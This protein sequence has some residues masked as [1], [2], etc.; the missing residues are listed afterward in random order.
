[1]RVHQGRR[2]LASLQTLVKCLNIEYERTPIYISAL[3]MMVG[4]IK[5]L[6]EGCLLGNKTVPRGVKSLFAP[7]SEGTFSHA[8][9]YNP[10]KST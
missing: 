7:M 4:E 2:A 5:I 10:A 1:M 3:S 9:Q 6:V 8:E